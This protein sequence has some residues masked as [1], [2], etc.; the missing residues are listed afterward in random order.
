M[1]GLS[2]RFLGRES[3]MRPEEIRTRMDLGRELERT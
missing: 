3:G 1:V 2:T